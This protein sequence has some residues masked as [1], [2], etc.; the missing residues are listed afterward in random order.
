MARMEDIQV[1][2]VIGAMCNFFMS[3]CVP[4]I[5]VMRSEVF[6]HSKCIACIGVT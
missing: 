4:R 5:A 6:W 3:F 1:G 2:K